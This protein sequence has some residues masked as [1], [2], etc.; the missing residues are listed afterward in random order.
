MR[1]LSLILGG[2]LVSCSSGAPS[3]QLGLPTERGTAAPTAAART[4]A[5]GSGAGSLAT[6]SPGTSGSP[7][8]SPN[9]SAS[10]SASASPSPSA[11][12]P[13]IVS[14]SGTQ[15]SLAVSYGAPMRAGRACGT[16]GQPGNTRGAIDA[17]AQDN[18]S[19][20]AL[21]ESLQSTTRATLSVDC[22]TVT[23]IFGAAAPAGTF[24]VTASTVVDAQGAAMDPARSDARVT[25]AD[26]A[27]PQV[28]SVQGAADVIEVRFSEP[29][30][31]IGEGSGVTMLG[32]YRLDG[33][34]PA[35]AIVACTDAGCRAVRITL[36]SGA[37]VTGRSYELRIAN[38]VDRVGKSIAPDPT[39]ITFRAG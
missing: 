22:T 8:A 2:L 31:Q 26:D 10:A 21:Q 30:L 24:T 5:P 32:N 13:T 20:A 16:S 19:D 1:L 25:I 27:R 35:A 3:G 12:P 38:V 37:L 29:M 7:T 6:P 9:A 36:R 15:L 23:F 11:A 4:S 34:T 14:A 17:V 28:T 18:T 33:A 39:T